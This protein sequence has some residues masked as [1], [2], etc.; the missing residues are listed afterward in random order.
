MLELNNRFEVLQ[1][2][3][4]GKNDIYANEIFEKLETREFEE[5][6]RDDKRKNKK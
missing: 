1:F 5:V 4:D 6:V 2:L 3:L